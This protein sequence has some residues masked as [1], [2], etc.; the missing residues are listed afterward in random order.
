MQTQET[1]LENGAG[2]VMCCPKTIRHEDDVIGCG[3]TNV[4]ED[5][6]EPGVFDCFDCG[7]HFTREAAEYT[8]QESP[9]WSYT[10]NDEHGAVLVTRN[11]GATLLFQGEDAKV[12]R[13]A[14]AESMA[15]DP[16]LATVF[17]NYSDAD[18]FQIAGEVKNARPVAL[19]VAT[20]AA[21]I[22][23]MNEILS[24]EYAFTV[25]LDGRVCRQ[26]EVA[27]TGDDFWVG[28]RLFVSGSGKPE[29]EVI[30]GKHFALTETEIAIA[31]GK[32]QL[33]WVH[34]S[35]NN[36]RKHS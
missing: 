26:L 13:A 35:T 20:V 6:S 3:S 25:R 29:G 28:T 24:N 32:A 34:A 16:D 17:N 10:A 1:R 14:M 18:A 5:P 9:P 8:K 19:A 31:F 12:V 33:D 23:G 2:Q 36:E 7:I 22:G 15:A 21:G 11:D 30:E 27:A 4:A